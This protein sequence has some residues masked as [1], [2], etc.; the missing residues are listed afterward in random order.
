WE[1]IGIAFQIRDDILNVLGEEEKYGKRIG[2][3]IAEGKPTLLLVNCLEHCE[4]REKENI[5]ECFHNYDKPKIEEVV[6]LFRK[7][8][9]ID[10]S[11][12]IAM[13]YLRSGTNKI[14]KINIKGKGEAEGKSREEIK[15]K[16]VALAEY[17]VERER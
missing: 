11:E 7:Y 15:E 5:Y 1:D 14:R 8:G 4:S 12:E 3:D 2:E 6:D 17:F 13:R 10:Y 16:M 9:S